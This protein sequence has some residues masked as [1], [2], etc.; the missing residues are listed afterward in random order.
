MSKLSQIFQKFKAVSEC[1]S[2]AFFPTDIKC[3]S[4]DY[5][6][7]HDNK[8][9]LCDKCSLPF[10]LVFC[11]VCGSNIDGIATV[12]E[13][14]RQ[15]NKAYEVA[16]APLLYRDKV[17]DLIRKFKFG[18]KK[19]LAKFFAQFLADCYH[20]NNFKVD[21]A[22]F[23]PVHKS[24]LKQR[25]F[26]QSQ[27]VA[28]YFASLVGLG[29]VDCFDKFVQHQD[30]ARLTREQRIA[31]IVGAMQLKPQVKDFL[32]YKTVLIVDDVFTTGTTVNQLSKIL[33]QS[34]A[35]KVYVLT[36]A[37]GTALVIEQNE[38]RSV[39]EFLQ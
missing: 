11:R 30:T 32:K 6:L 27:L 23:V 18:R 7:C 5:E 39:E 13:F 1:A 22:T 10:N 2:E 8:Y 38:R 19:Y 26:N 29:L 31:T 14:C 21:F 4:C 34:G 36:I 25:G 37:T 35:F 33:K 9:G 17:A 24:K 12:C 3:I 20:K 16:R 15:E 28:E